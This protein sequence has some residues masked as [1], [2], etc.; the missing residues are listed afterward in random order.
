MTSSIWENVQMK[1]TITDVLLT[2]LDVLYVLAS[3]SF[4]L[5]I[6]GPFLMSATQLPNS[7]TLPLGRE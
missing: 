6:V 2:L 4:V 1:M 7:S 5:D 3:L